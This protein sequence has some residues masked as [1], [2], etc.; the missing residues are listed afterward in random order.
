MTPPQPTVSVLIPAYNREAYVGAAI[1]SV[2]GQTFDDLEL[3]VVDDGSTDGTAREIAAFSDP[4][5]R[6]LTQRNAGP[7]AAMNTGLRAARGRYLA[8]LGSDDLWLPEFL[9]VQVGLLER[10]PDVGLVYCRA[11]AMDAAGEPL[12]DI[13][14]KPLRYPGDT[15]RSMLYEDCTCDITVVVRREIIERS[16]MYDE[17]L[18]RSID[19]DMWLRAARHCEFAF[20]D[21]VLARFR[22]HP[23]NLTGTAFNDVRLACRERVLDKVFADPTLPDDAKAMRPL[24]YRNLQVEAALSWLAL[25]RRDHALAALARAVGA[26]AGPLPTVS[27]FLWFATLRRRLVGHPLGRRLDVWQSTARQRLREAR[28]AGAAPRGRGRGSEFS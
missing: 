27:R 5:L 2:L 4:R 21:Q 18:S 13:W 1:R 6:W 3:I 16:G 12:P 26:G 28:A 19:W 23:G 10:R 15:L 8:R 9:A 20:T 17:S 24:A 22:R 14:G 11:E 7:S 25:G